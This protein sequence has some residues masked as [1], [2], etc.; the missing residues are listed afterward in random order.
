MSV[1]FTF[2]HSVTQFTPKI[3]TDVSDLITKSSR[4]GFPFS[5][6]MFMF[7]ISIYNNVE[8]LQKH[9]IL[10]PPSRVPSVT[11]WKFNLV[12]NLSYFHRN[13]L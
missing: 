5:K 10:S 12:I 6:H 2:V 11:I 3:Y 7:Y 4:I 13:E 8:K 1:S 9:V